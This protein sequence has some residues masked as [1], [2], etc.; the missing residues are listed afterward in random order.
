MA[1]TA[2]SANI[3]LQAAEWEARSKIH[4]AHA[5]LNEALRY[6]DE[7]YPNLALSEARKLVRQGTDLVAGLAE[8]DV[9]QQILRDTVIETLTQK[10]NPSD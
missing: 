8:A 7:G 3:R 1:L 2:A 4:I 10:E 6:V 9:Y 5:T